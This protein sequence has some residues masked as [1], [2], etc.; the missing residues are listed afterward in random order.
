[1]RED[2]YI[3]FKAS[4][5]KRTDPLEDAVV[6]RMKDIFAAT[7]LHSY[8]AAVQNTIEIMEFIGAEVPEHLYDLR[9]DFHHAA[10]TA[11]TYKAK[12]LP[13]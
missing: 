5:V 11:E 6:L 7:A 4:D 12:R 2:K 1:M 8:S 3:V 13:D 10:L 9:D